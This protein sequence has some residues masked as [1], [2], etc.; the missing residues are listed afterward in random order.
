MNDT[1][2]LSSPAT[3]EF[4]EVPI[5][6]EDADLLALDKPAGLLVSPDRYDPDRPNLMKLLH[7]DIERSAAWSRERGLT[8]LMNAH[9]LDFPTSGVILLAKNKTALIHLANQFGEAKPAKVYAALTRGSIRD[10]NFSN[11]AKLAPNPLRP[12]MMKVD[13]KNGKQA[14]TEFQVRERFTGYLLLECRPLTGRTHQIRAHLK[15]QGLPMVGDPV[16]GGPPLLLSSLKRDYTLKRGKEERPLIGRVALHAEKLTIKHPTS[17]A[18]IT[19]DAPW[20]K[21]FTVA[22]KYLR[23]YAASTGDARSETPPAI[24]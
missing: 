5:L 15:N 4:W 24:D 3:Q 8:Y 14:R 16:Y 18:Q 20:P 2:K 22:V 11:A 12:G 13:P 23:R 10:D 9:R 21:D 7:R 1:V 17:G 6:F 19:I